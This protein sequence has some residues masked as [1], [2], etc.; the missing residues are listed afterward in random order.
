M[1]KKCPFCGST[2]VDIIVSHQKDF[3]YYAIFRPGESSHIAVE[4]QNC[5]ARGPVSAATVG[6]A[7][8]SINRHLEKARQYWDKREKYY[9]VIDCNERYIGYIA[10]SN[11]TTEPKSDGDVIQ[12]LKPSKFPLRERMIDESVEVFTLYWQKKRCV[13]DD[14]MYEN[15]ILTLTSE[16]DSLNLMKTSPN[17]FLP[18]PY[19]HGNKI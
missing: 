1:M 2:D 11:L 6:D 12:V 8:S 7:E 14:Q 9:P 5:R 3:P 16:Y 10:K 18:Y 19:V 17:L 13:I 15:W 4:C